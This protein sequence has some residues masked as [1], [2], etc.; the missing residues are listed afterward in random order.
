MVNVVLNVVSVG[1]DIVLI[2]LTAVVCKFKIT[3]LWS[4]NGKSN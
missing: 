2:D 1:S 4:E 3:P